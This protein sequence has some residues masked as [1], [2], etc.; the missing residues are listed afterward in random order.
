[1][2]YKE[3]EREIKKLGLVC[4][5]SCYFVSIYYPAPSSY[6]LAYMSREMINRII[7]TSDISKLPENVGNKI[8]TLCYKLARTPI[9]ERGIVTLD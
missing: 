3:F 6:L 5:Y 8:L 7:T 1:M 2:T 9:D 4:D